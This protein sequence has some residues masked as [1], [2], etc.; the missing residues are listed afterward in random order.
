MT[1]RGLGRTFSALLAVALLVGAFPV[2]DRVTAAAFVLALASFAVGLAAPGR[3]LPAVVFACVI[4]GAGTSAAGPHGIL[5][6]P[7]LIAL[8]FGTGASVRD[9]VRQRP[10]PRTPLDRAADV[11]GVFWFGSAVVAAL[12]ARS[13]WALGHGLALRAVNAIG[14]SDAAAMH[15]TLLGI[16]AVFAGLTVFRAARR[17][18]AEIRRRA[19]TALVAG[20]VLSAGVALLQSRGWI[21]ASRTEFWR[22]LGRFH[23]LASDPNAAGVVAALALGPAFF[24]ALRGGRRWLWAL[25]CAV[26][27][28][29]VAVSGSRSGI[30]MAALAIA[31]VGIAEVRGMPRWAR[32]ALGL[33]A[34]LVT[35]ILFAAS[36][37]RGGAGERLVSLFDSGTPIAYRTSSRG[38]FWTA[39]LDAF[40]AAPLGGIGWNAFSWRLPTLA[41][42]RGHAIAVMD[43]PGNFYLQVLCETGIGGALL[44]ALFAAA[45]GRAVS[46]ALRRG[47]RE[48]G[49]A[50]SLLAFAPA[51]AVGSHLLAAEA[52]VAA[53]LLLA[54]VAGDAPGPRLASPEKGGRVRG[55]D[56]AAALAAAAGWVVLLAPTARETEAFRYAPEMG[57]YA[58]EGGP[59]GFRWMRPRAA[60]RVAAGGRRRLA[61]ASPLGDRPNRLR[62]LSGGGVL[63]AGN[64]GSERRTFA[65]EAPAS[66]PAIF[67]FESAASFRPSYRGSSDSR[68][69]SLQAFAA[70]P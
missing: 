41:A 18:S 30:L 45:A 15:R 47:G 54:E 12:W 56:L 39:A 66:G 31:A 23:G 2:G 61:V 33:F 62:I 38:L 51:L 17:A 67:R 44:F 68:L 36:G 37:G 10:S 14:T 16:A 69:L 32:P 58:V 11:L 60:I 21:G 19:R 29:G 35:V 34:L 53:F 57:M 22:V 64:V 26:L 28:G 7:A 6:W 55:R 9:A 46:D 27:A 40:R 63:F 52:A 4:T 8:W 48:R 5:P 25:A 59:G 24:A 1:A 49:S 42:A 20:A 65:L 3:T 50:A 13:L 70:R 43:N